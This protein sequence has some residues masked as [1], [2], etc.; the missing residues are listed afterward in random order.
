MYAKY[1]TR[2]PEQT[3][4]T[5]SS[6]QIREI[7]F[8]SFNDSQL[9]FFENLSNFFLSYVAHCLSSFPGKLGTIFR[10]GE[11]AIMCRVSLACAREIKADR[12]FRAVIGQFRWRPREMGRIEFRGERENQRKEKKKKID[13]IG[14]WP[15][16]IPFQAVY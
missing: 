11:G 7:S 5:F 12:R 15:I 2:N 8:T 4:Q 16:D 13:E 9:S 14:G 1:Y 10:E 6:K 3:Q